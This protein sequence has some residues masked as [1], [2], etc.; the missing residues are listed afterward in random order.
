VP[1]LFQRNSR[2]SR[3]RQAIPLARDFGRGIAGGGEKP[4]AGF[5]R[6]FFEEVNVWLVKVVP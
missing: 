1:P 6:V 2:S 5:S 4:G 3:T